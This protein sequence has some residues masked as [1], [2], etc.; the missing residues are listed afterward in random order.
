MTQVTLNAFATCILIVGSQCTFAAATDFLGCWKDVEITS[1]KVN[2]D[3]TKVPA[4]CTKLI[5]LNK[6][7]SN[8]AGRINTS[9]YQV[10]SENGNRFSVNITSLTDKDGKELKSTFANPRQYLL[11]GNQL[12]ITTMTIRENQ[13]SPQSQL[14]LDSVAERMESSG[15]DWN[16]PT[17]QKEMDVCDYRAQ[18]KLLTGAERDRFLVECRQGNVSG[19]P[20]SG[21]RQLIQ[22]VK[23]KEPGS[24]AASIKVTGKA[25]L[26]TREAAIACHFLTD[27][28]TRMDNDGEITEF[29]FLPE[30][31][32]ATIWGAYAPKGLKATPAKVF[33][34]FNG[35][36]KRE[37]ANVYLLKNNFG[38]W[39]CDRG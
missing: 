10:V 36:T 4:V 33:L 9:A 39:K 25:P 16:K 35:G 7:V 1:V 22:V 31:D 37:Y 14:R 3:Q 24:N 6:I 34:S 8:C 11:Q 38:E 26:S 20:S 32:G 18:D 5:L 2:G 19:Q 13:S 17:D 27:T 12:A 29:N 21:P 15:C 23:K 30:V 28:S